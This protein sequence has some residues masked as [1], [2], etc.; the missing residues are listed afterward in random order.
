MYN[1]RILFGGAASAGILTVGLAA[2][3]LAQAIARADTPVSSLTGLTQ[4]LGVSAAGNV[5]CD[6]TSLSFTPA[7]TGATGVSCISNTTGN[8]STTSTAST[9]SPTSTSSPSSDA[10][11]SGASNLDASSTSNTS[12]IP[13]ALPDLSVVSGIIPG[14]SPGQ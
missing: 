2:P 5:L 4:D 7:L 1:W 13:G 12:V 3:A 10:A 6:Q 14:M 8:S 11:G 9:A